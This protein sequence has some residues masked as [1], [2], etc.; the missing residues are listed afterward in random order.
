GAHAARALDAGV[1]SDRDGRVREVRLRLS[2]R[3]EARLADAPLARPEGELRV[4]A[5]LLLGRIGEEQLED[6]ALGV[7]RAVVRRVDDH[8]FRGRAAA[9]GREHALAFDLDHARPAVPVLPHPFRVAEVRDADAVA[10]CG[11]E[12]RLTGTGLDLDAVQPE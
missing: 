12:D 3:R 6:H 1:E 7:P 4:R 9:R 11:L 10:L 2:A 8:A 5:V